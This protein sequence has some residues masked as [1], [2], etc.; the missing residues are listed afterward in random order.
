MK[1]Y[2][3]FCMKIQKIVSATTGCEISKQTFLPATAQRGICLV[4]K[5][6]GPYTFEILRSFMIRKE[7][8]NDLSR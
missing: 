7:I 6:Y 8:Q 4:Q 5:G 3:L 2:K 1:K